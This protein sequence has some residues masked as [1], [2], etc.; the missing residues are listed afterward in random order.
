MNS[1]ISNLLAK[2][3]RNNLTANLLDGAFFGFAMGFASFVTILPLFV[4]SMTGSAILIGLIPAIHNVGWQLPQ[5]F[6][7][8]LVARQKRYR[9]LVL[10]MT[11]HERLPVPGIGIGGAGAALAG[12]FRRTGDYFWDADLA[13][14]GRRADRQ[15]LAIDD[16]QDF[17]LRM[18]RHFPGQP[19]FCGQPARQPWRYH[20]RLHLATLHRAARLRLVL[21]AGQRDDGDLIFLSGAH[22]RALPRA[23]RP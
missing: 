22:P 11:I 1:D 4:R 12:Q 21:S 10:A 14:A 17:P 13:R 19:V 2:D 7:A 3:L 8:G 20:G 16:R 6:T 23:V 5:L 15:S 18:A 9:P